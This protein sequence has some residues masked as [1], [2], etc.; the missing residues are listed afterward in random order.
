MSDS[1]GLYYQHITIIYE[2]SSVVNKF[3]VS[4][5]DDARVVFY[6]HHMF[7]VQATDY[8]ISKTQSPHTQTVLIIFKTVFSTLQEFN[9]VSDHY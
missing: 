1:C 3:E 5:T 4:L 6:D 7:I 9:S 2:N 8:S